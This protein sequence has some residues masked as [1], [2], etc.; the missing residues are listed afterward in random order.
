MSLSIA[1]LYLYSIL[2]HHSKHCPFPHVLS[3]YT[4]STSKAYSKAQ[5]RQH[6]YCTDK[7][8]PSNRLKYN[9]GIDIFFREN[10]THRQWILSTKSVV[11]WAFT[12]Y[13]P[14]CSIYPTRIE[15]LNCLYIYIHIIFEQWTFQSLSIF[16]DKQLMTGFMFCTKN[17]IHPEL[18][19]H[20][21][22]FCRKNGMKLQNFA[23]CAMGTRINGIIVLIVLIVTL[24]ISK[25]CLQNRSLIRFLQQNTE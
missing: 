16:V 4:Y 5:H 23:C 7:Y 17:G 15:L 1:S 24:N 2:E 19:Y 11:E 25:I 3:K 12:W 18:K 8:P 13:T 20:V 10:N 9:S 6:H 21:C 14:I 22:I